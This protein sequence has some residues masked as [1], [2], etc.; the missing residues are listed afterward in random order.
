MAAMTKGAAPAAH[1]LE[2]GFAARR[3]PRYTCGMSG[4][5]DK[6]N[7]WMVVWVTYGPHEAQ[8]VAGR[9]RSEGIQ[10]LVHQQAGASA[11]GIHI[12][13]LGEVRVLVHPADYEVALEILAPEPG[14]PL[15]EDGSRIVFDSD[16]EG[17]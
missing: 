9:L 14:K 17:E 1:A 2:R 15:P 6:R 8:I 13:Q 10:S 4:N 5:A 7:D 3:Q 12:G 11:M 16:D